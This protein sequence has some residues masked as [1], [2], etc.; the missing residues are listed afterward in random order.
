MITQGLKLYW[1]PDR[2]DNFC[3]ATAQGELDARAAGYTFVRVEGYVNP[4]AGPNTVPL[5]LY[6][7]T[8]RGDYFCTATAQGELDAR[9]AG[10]TF[11]R[12]EGYVYPSVVP[13][14]A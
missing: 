1:N 13:I 14:T 11:V 6:L 12:V 10:Y 4:N 8:D 9:A 7:G 2:R 5:N 3:T